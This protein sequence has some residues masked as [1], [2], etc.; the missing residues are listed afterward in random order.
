MLKK[1]ILHEGASPSTYK[2]RRPRRLSSFSELSAQEME[3]LFV[4]DDCSTD[5]FN[6]SVLGYDVAVQSELL[7]E[8]IT[9]L[10][11]GK[12][13]IIL[14]SYFLDMTN[15]EIGKMLNFGLCCGA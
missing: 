7:T 11:K 10:P 8:A 2:K 14:L 5:Y 12:H 9:A 4:L 13:N 3:M 6:F 15:R 1:V